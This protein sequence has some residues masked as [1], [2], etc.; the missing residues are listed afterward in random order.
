MCLEID[1]WNIR[2]PTSVP[3]Y[4]FDPQNC[5]APTRTASQFKLSATKM[6]TSRAVSDW[7]C[8]HVRNNWNIPTKLAVDEGYLR[9]FRRCF[10]L[11]LRLPRRC[12]YMHMK[13][14]FK[15]RHDYQFVMKPHEPISQW[16]GSI[17]QNNW[18]IKPTAAKS[19]NLAFLFVLLVVM[20]IIM[21]MMMIII[22]MIIIIICNSFPVLHRLLVPS[23]FAPNFP[24]IPSSDASLSRFITLFTP[25]S[26][27]VL[28]AILF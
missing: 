8:N 18:F 3:Q 4:W 27:S 17:S 20:I 6:V 25:P 23:L 5:D 12:M 15:G 24:S 21:K 1:C 16:R 26:P 9:C 13:I 28:R 7:L 19:F 2:K 14:A 10:N 22:I 11:T